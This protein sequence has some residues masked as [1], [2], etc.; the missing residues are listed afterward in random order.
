MLFYIVHIL[1]VFSEPFWPSSSSSL[2]GDK[3]QRLSRFSKWG[4]SLRI[5]VF[6]MY[7]ILARLTKHLIRNINMYYLFICKYICD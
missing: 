3:H 6:H 1:Y 2:L 7:L 5:T 4:N